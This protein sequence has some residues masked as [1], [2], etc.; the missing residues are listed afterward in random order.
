MKTS[1]FKRSIAGMLA[2]AFLLTT[3]LSVG[4]TTAF[5][6]GTQ[7]KVYI[8]SFP[9]S[10]DVSSNT[11]WGHPAHSYLNGWSAEKSEWTITRAI[12]GYNGQ[13]C[14][15]IEP[16]VSQQTGDTLTQ[17]DENFWDNYP[18]DYNDAISPYTIKLFI[19]RIM[20]YGYTGNLSTSWRSDNA[21]A[22][23]LCNLIATQ[24]L[25]WE[26]V[27]GERD[28]SFNKLSTGSKNAVLERIANHPLKS[29]IMSHY[30]RIA[31]SVR[32][33]STIPS[34]M[35]LSE[36]SADNYKMS[37]NGSQYVLE[38]TD[39]NNVLS[40]CS[41][42]SNDSNMKFSVS[43]NKLKITSTTAPSGSVT[44]TASKKNSQRMGV[45]TWSDGKVG[46][47]GGKQDIVSYS[48]PVS[49]QVY[50]FARIK[51]SFGSAK[52]VK[53]S[54]DGDVKGVTFS[55][56]GN[57]VSKTVTTASNGEV[58]IDNLSPGVY[59]VT[60]QTGD[61]YVPQEVRRVT[62]VSGQT[63]TVT[64]SNKLKRGTLKVTKTSEDGL[65]EGI[66]FRLYGTS[67][68]GQEV[69]EYAVTDKNGAATFHDVLVG[70]GYTLQ[71]VDTGVRYVIPEDQT[72]SVEWNKVTQKTFSNTLKKF[73]VTVTKSD[74][75]TG[76]PQGD[77]SLAGAKYGIYKGKQL[78]DEYV[79]DQNGQF[80]TKDYV[81]GDDWTIREIAPSEGYTLNGQTYSVGAQ[82]KKYTVEYNKTAVDVLE[83]IAKGKIFI[84]KHSDDGS[85][86]I[87]TPEVGAEFEVYLKSAGSYEDANDTERDLLVCDEN[88]FA[89]SQDLP[90]GVYTVH[91]TKGWEGRELMPAF[92]V[93]VSEDG[94]TYRYLINNAEFE[95]LIE[96]VK[97][98]AETGNVIPAAGIS[99]KIK[100]SKTGEYVK[101]HINYPTPVDIDVYSTDSTGRLMMPEALKFGDYELIEVQTAYGY[102]LDSKPVKFKVDGTNAVVTVEKH[103]V[104]QKGII[105]VTKTGEV[106]ST[107]REAKSTYQPVYEMRGLAGAVYEVTAEEDI[108]TLDGT[109]RAIEGEVVATITTDENGIA[110]TGE[111]YLGRYSVKE[112]TAPEGMVLSD[113]VH[114]VELVY[115]GQEVEITEASASVVNQRQKAS[116]DLKKGVEVDDV[117]DIGTHCEITAASFGLFAAEKLTAADGKAIPK[118]GMLEIVS[119]DENGKAVFTTDIPVGAKLY[120]KEVSAD[121]HY[122]VSDEKYPV[123]FDYAGQ[124]TASVKLSVNEGKTIG[125]KLLR[126]KVEGKKVDEDGYAVEGAVFGL[127]RS[128]ETEF[129]QDTAILVTVSDET[130]AFVFKD[131]PY[132]EWV[133]REIEP[134]DGY[135]LNETVF[136][137]TIENDAQVIEIEVVNRF[138]RGSVT[139]TKVD[140]EYPDHKL[141][142][143]VFVIYRD[144]D[145]DG[146]FVSDSDLAVGEMTEVSTGIYSLDNLKY[147]GY[148]L[149]EKT[150]PSG[151]VKD[152]GYYFFKI[153]ED[154]ETVTVE[155]KAGVGFA[156]KPAKGE[157]EITKRDVADGTLLPNAGFRIKDADGNIVVEGRTDENGIARFT[158]RVGKYTYEEFDAPEGYLIDTTPHEFEITENGQIVKAEMTDKKEPVPDNPKT[159]ENDHRLLTALFIASA[160]TIAGTVTIACLKKRKD[161]DE[162]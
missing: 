7:E 69:D 46:P 41:F 129:N 158:L 25:I 52:I 123:L 80:V 104:A 59:T 14:Y 12:G 74:S 26:A 122:V 127:F 145:G 10:G 94:Q 153:T 57:G 88:G 134:A 11:G 155:N 21:G 4:G 102:V 157:L 58:Q 124:E 47:K 55:I 108:V 90:Y 70:T 133:V 24:I 35:R 63:A 39:T 40:G 31:E 8:V 49:D 121:S 56:E 140:E 132:G 54:E 97:K 95:A 89:Q 162:E 131:I 23:D 48:Q 65:N 150:A 1:I 135:V 27:I 152:D 93:F 6:A 64:F 130:G 117:F 109:V 82:A 147:G 71:E 103:N 9:R 96:I 67:M 159:G 119:C 18:D 111:L 33:H 107:V 100:N 110:K 115:A 116:L 76:S 29:K 83:T 16:G 85:T 142:G 66:K 75:E 126:G 156:N 137:A 78:V 20:Q 136:P 36:G 77:A 5:A 151:F 44:I 161:E 60:E 68:S 154:G 146:K 45:I 106:F 114:E 62:V 32:T 38:L 84:I 34:F 118:D 43:G 28:D 149:H 143:A 61:K 17:K 101:Q 19:G 141:T 42:S 139:T 125:N 72:A 37:W 128:D 99:F 50:G 98:D 92:D 87:E 138:I 160:G 13:A 148:F 105:S 15:C 51:V 113:E 81:C 30:N 112:I 2:F 91:Q 86:Q 120:V 22:D 53:T 79:T 73:K 3:M 144:T